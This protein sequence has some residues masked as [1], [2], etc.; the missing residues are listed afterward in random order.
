MSKFDTLFGNGFQDKSQ[1]LVDN[2]F[3]QYSSISI[4]LIFM[5]IPS[6]FISLFLHNVKNSWSKNMSK[7]VANKSNKNTNS[8]YTSKRGSF[9]IHIVFLLIVVFVDHYNECKNN[10][11]TD[12][13]NDDDNDNDDY[14][15]DENNNDDNGNY[16][17]VQFTGALTQF[18][19][20]MM[21]LYAF[22]VILQKIP[23]Y[24]NFITNNKN[25]TLGAILNILE[26]TVLFFLYNWVKNY[27]KQYNYIQCSTQ[28]L[29]NNDESTE[30]STSSF[31]FNDHPNYTD[32]TAMEVTTKKTVITTTGNPNRE[33][34]THLNPKNTL[35]PKDTQNETIDTNKKD[36]TT[37]SDDTNQSDH[38]GKCLCMYQKWWFI[39]LCVLVG[40]MCIAVLV[41]LYTVWY[42]D[43][44]NLEERKNVQ[45][46]LESGDESSRS[47]EQQKGLI[48]I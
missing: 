43:K 32:P 33:I 31:I 21:P 17:I 29:L 8:A 46:F 37:D 1:D 41:Q 6:K 38:R 39:V 16:T 24:N 15:D 2:I 45:R 26:G 19:L 20:V 22:T 34:I 5:Y 14:E 13:D 23:I 10:N 12:D 36:N 27:Q 9:L 44:R 35:V 28:I 42:T 3:T 18:I 40:G 4:L 48:F 11:D 7:N 47:N 30:A 25:V